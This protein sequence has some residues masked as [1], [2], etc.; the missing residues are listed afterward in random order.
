MEKKTS[1]PEQTGSSSD[2]KS[3]ASSTGRGSSS[4]SAPPRVILHSVNYNDRMYI[5]S[6]SIDLMLTDM[7]LRARTEQERE[8]VADMVEQFRKAC[9]S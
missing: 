8:L 7:H 3:S 9:R 6:Q 1:E 5:D 4:S 2:S